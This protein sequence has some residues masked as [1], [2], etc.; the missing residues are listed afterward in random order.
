MVAKSKD[1]REYMKIKIET[2]KQADSGDEPKW[3]LT[4]AAKSAIQTALDEVNGKATSFT[5]C[6]ASDIYRLSRRADHYLHDQK[7]PE[8]DRAGATLTSR[9]AG[10]RANAYKNTAISTDV[11]LTRFGARWY[12]TDVKRAKVYPRA[13]E[14][15]R[16]TITD[17]AIDNLVRRTLK[18]F[19]R[20]PQ[21]DQQQ[22]AA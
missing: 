6:D 12:L 3:T 9:Q 15:F 16:V 20:V 8:S 14:I 5:L 22:I 1:G 11:T 13:S 19:G 2:E 7:V 10:P 18:A 21:S 17:R 4:D